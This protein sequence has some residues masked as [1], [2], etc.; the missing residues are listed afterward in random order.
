MSCGQQTRGP[1]WS[2]S[3]LPQEGALPLEEQGRAGLYALTGRLLLAPD[4]RVMACLA[5]PA[6]MEPVRN[7]NPLGVVLKELIGTARR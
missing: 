3:A 1:D 7:D 6:A 2:E 4:D 5:N